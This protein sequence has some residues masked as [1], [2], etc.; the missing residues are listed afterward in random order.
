MKKFKA[1]VNKAPNNMVV[2]LISRTIKPTEITNTKVNVV[3]ES[4]SIPLSKTEITKQVDSAITAIENPIDSKIDTHL[5]ETTKKLAQDSGS[6]NLIQKVNRAIKKG[7]DVIRKINEIEGKLDTVI[8]DVKITPESELSQ[9]TFEPYKP[10]RAV[11]VK[12]VYDKSNFSVGK[13]DGKPYVTDSFILEFNSNIDIPKIKDA[14]KQEG[15]EAIIPKEEDLKK[16]EIVEV[17][18]D[19]ELEFVR[20]E[21]DGIN[22]SMQR[23]YYDYFNKKYPNATFMAV[24]PKKPIV[25][26]SKGKNVGLIMPVDLQGSGKKIT[27]IWKKPKVIQETL[28]KVKPK[29]K[30]QRISDEISPK[31][32]PPKKPKTKTEL[33]SLSSPYGNKT[34]KKITERQSE[35]KVDDVQKVPEDFKVSE[36]AKAILAEFGIP[37]SERGL[38]G[39]QLGVYKQLTEKVRVQALYDVTT[40]TH[41][42]VHAID[43]QLDFSK[44]II[45]STGRGAEIRKRLTDIYEDLYL[46]GKRTHPLKLRI[47][48]G[49]AVF[50]E[51]YLYDPASI[52]AKYPDLVDSFIE[53][54][55][56]YY[57]PQFTKL[58]DRMNQLVEDYA[59]LSP[60]QRIGSRIR[61]GKEVV[62]NQKGFTWK[63][64]AEYEVFNRFEPL[65]RYGQKAG[66]AETW[67]DPYVQAFNIMNKNSI[68]ANWV[69]GN[70]SPILLRDGNFRIE[71]GSVAD[72][73]NEVK[74]V[75]LDTPSSPE[76]NQKVFRVYLVARRVVA[77][78]NKLN[79]LK[80]ELSRSELSEEDV[81]LISSSIKKLE[82]TIE[83]D[84][85][86]LQDATATIEKYQKPFE[87]ATYLYDKV[88]EN[89]IDLSIENDL[90]SKELG[91]QYKNEPGYASFRR[92]IDEDLN[93]VGTH[94]TSSKSKVT[95]FKERSGSQLDIIDPVFSQIESINEIIGKALENRLW[96]KV[97]NLTKDNPEIARRFEKM[98]AKPAIDSEGKISFPQENDP[99][100]IRVFRGGK[101]EFY[102][103][104]PEFIAVTKNLR[105]KEFD[106]FVQ[107]LRIPSSLFTRL[108]TSA[109]PLFAVSNI[110]VDQFSALA[111]TK[112][113]FTP[114]ADPVKGLI[115]YIKSDTGMQA[116]IA[117]GGRRQTLAAFYDLSPEDISHKLTGGETKIEQV[118]D[119]IDSTLNV[120]ETPANLSEIATRFSEFQRS[121][122]KGEPMSVAMFRASEVTTPFQLQGNLAGRFGQ[123]FVKSIP[124]LNAIV[125]VL[126]KFG[127]ASKDNPKRMGSVIASIII[128]GLTAAISAYEMGS[129]KQKRLLAEQPVRNLSRYIYLPTPGGEKLIKIRIPEQ[130]GVFTG[131]SYL[132]LAQHYQGNEA[133]FKDYVDVVASTVPEQ[134]HFWEPKK[135]LASWLPQAISPSIEVG[136]NQK[137]FPNLSPIVPPY[138]ED[139]PKQ[140]QYTSYTSESAKFIGKLLGASPMMVEYWVKN[141]FGVIG[142]LAVGKTPGNP[143]IIQER[144][145]VM[146]GRAYNR[147]YE[148]RKLVNQQYDE[149]IKH[150]P[151]QYSFNEKYDIKQTKKIYTKMSD[152]L[153]DIRDINKKID[154]PE[155]IK[156]MTFDLLLTIDSDE[157]VIRIAPKLFALN[158]E[159]DK[160]KITLSQ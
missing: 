86:S 39:R 95:S 123:E 3:P 38:R 114:V 29:V 131:M 7:E 136:F 105:G 141:Q 157:D 21:G 45:D 150:H 100:I 58:L 92:F 112:S 80:N 111:Q 118:S 26:K 73:L 76:H 37:I 40:V 87:R 97:A 60:E 127:R 48:E 44:K 25:V 1:D 68:V 154:L 30:E 78:N 69:R 22:V 129:E 108:T 28:V 14:P 119:V 46:K 52:K 160:V 75:E 107:L 98:P 89:L 19:E 5:I 31:T 133:V 104:G 10:A 67:D 36:R 79:D 34:L 96:V 15:V 18:T 65:K 63:Q 57:N 53:P 13:F 51:N 66:V 62:D 72:Y 64:R 61:T 35:A 49:L 88:N 8:E 11:P 117:L 90:I 85:F 54:G 33:S 132:Y 110:T 16:V 9:P 93:A 125:Q 71:E 121:V 6:K 43:E 77:D 84:D 42:A 144:Q 140:M 32:L 134:V 145:Y 27:T 153:T 99:G 151:L 17:Q 24:E 47:Q 102:K 55:G 12:R 4:S 124:Y 159:V 116:Y 149:I 143:L 142:G 2:P 137:T 148:N 126:Y 91:E 74:K 158:H 94:K 81:E 156:S 138:M 82:K 115:K 152:T 83:N 139:L 103:A 20:L 135:A 109:N 146:T 50:F 23:K 106:G 130:M 128:A 147:F 155:N 41:E 120:F 122:E 101:R 113:G 56:Q 59:K 70:K